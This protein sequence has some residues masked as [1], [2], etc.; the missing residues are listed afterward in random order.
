MSEKKGFNRRELLKLFGKVTL[1]VGAGSV[2]ATL[3]PGCGSS[4][5]NNVPDGCSL[6]LQKDV[7][8]WEGYV[9][10]YEYFQCQADQASLDCYCYPGDYIY[11]PTGDYLK[12]NGK[13]CVCVRTRLAE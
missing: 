1:A 8:N 9:Y 12:A 2:V 6:L 11:T 7:T 13:P 10:N 4:N 5:G 3:L